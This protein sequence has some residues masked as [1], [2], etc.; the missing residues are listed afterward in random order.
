M[1]R[2]RRK[3]DETNEVEDAFWANEKNK[4]KRTKHKMDQLKAQGWDDFNP[5]GHR[6]GRD[7]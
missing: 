6:P 5:V 7:F 1:G 3:S 4:N 2:C